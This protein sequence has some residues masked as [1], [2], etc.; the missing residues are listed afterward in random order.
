MEEETM[1]LD[2]TIEIE[3]YGHDKIEIGGVT[4]FVRPATAADHMI[5]VAMASDDGYENLDEP[6]GK[7]ASGNYLAMSRIAR[8]IGPVL[9]DGTPAPCTMNNK[10]IFFGNNPHVIIELIGQLRKR[11]ESAEKNSQH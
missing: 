10:R 3:E 2:L 1:P 7:I 5:A 4:F 11:Q 8:W 9:K 6:E